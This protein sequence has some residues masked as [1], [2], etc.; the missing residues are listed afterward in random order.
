VDKGVVV[1][2]ADAV[3]QPFAMVIEFECASVALSAVLG[4]FEDHFVTD[5]ALKV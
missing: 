2:V 3:V 1:F 5:N 4:V